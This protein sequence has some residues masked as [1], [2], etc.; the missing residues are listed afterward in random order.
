MEITSLIHLLV[1]WNLF[2]TNTNWANSNHYR[3]TFHDFISDQR[4]T[5]KT[6]LQF[7]KIIRAIGRYV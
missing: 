3:K 5:M 6:G 7:I 4:Q 1:N 2:I